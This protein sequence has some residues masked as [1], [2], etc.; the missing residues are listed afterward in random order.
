MQSRL[1]VLALGLAL[2]VASPA[3]VKVGVSSDGDLDRIIDFLR[4]RKAGIR[5]ITRAHVTLE[6]V[7][8][9]RVGHP[10]SLSD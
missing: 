7:F 4:D 5:G 8:L 9:S 3:L 10:R 6:Q 2:T 1:G